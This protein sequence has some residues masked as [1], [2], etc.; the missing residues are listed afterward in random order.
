MRNWLA[1]LRPGCVAHA[2][3]ER[4]DIHQR[5]TAHQCSEDQIYHEN[6]TLKA[7]QKGVSVS[8]EHSI[9]DQ[10]PEDI[11]RRQNLEIQIQTQVQI[12]ISFLASSHARLTQFLFVF[13]PSDILCD[14]S[15]VIIRTLLAVGSFI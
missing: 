5:K 10:V 13:P 4:E 2:L 11:G 1:R 15:R 9:Q 12:S 14:L 6:K 7:H 8:R 3:G